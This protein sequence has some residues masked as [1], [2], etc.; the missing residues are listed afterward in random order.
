MHAALTQL[1]QTVCSNSLEERREAVLQVGLRLEKY[2]TNPDTLAYYDTIL[3]A[4]LHQVAL[5]LAD[6]HALRNGDATP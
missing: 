4:P 6:Q 2:A 5:S 1:V 3:T